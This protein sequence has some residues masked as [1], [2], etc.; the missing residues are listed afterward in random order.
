MR[1]SSIVYE[2][3]Y[4]DPFAVRNRVL[5]QEFYPP[6][7]LENIIRVEGMESDEV[8]EISKIGNFCGERTIRATKIL[9][10]EDEH[11]KNFVKNVCKFNDDT[12]LEVETYF[13]MQLGEHDLVNKSIHQ[14]TDPIMA[15]V[16]YLTPN[17]EPA[18]GTIFYAHKKTNWNGVNNDRVPDRAFADIYPDKR[19][20]QNKSNFQ[21]ESIVGNVFN[22]IVLYDSKLLHAPGTCFGKTK[23][24]CRLTQTSFIFKVAQ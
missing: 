11:T 6:D 17:P 18:S 2:N 16:V 8:Y 9:P 13:T 14:D 20:D 1:L 19:A 22:R 4:P 12:K 23:E 5:K 21:V 7:Y 3:F 15:I 10:E 24:D